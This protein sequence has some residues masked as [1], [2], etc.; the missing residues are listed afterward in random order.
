MPQ[1]KINVE[2]ERITFLSTL[3]N[4]QIYVTMQQRTNHFSTFARPTEVTYAHLMMA[5]VM[6]ANFSRALEV[7]REQM[8][9]GVA[10]GVRSTRAALAACA[11][12]GNIDVALEVCHEKVTENLNGLTMPS[13][14]GKKELPRNCTRTQLFLGFWY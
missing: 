3:E 13:R 4:G 10:P 5:S 9:A 7:W 2:L 14:L 1:N 8:V 12:A 11:G 6:A